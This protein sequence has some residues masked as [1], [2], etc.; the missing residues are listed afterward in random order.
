MTPCFTCPVALGA[1]S[2]ALEKGYE[3]LS[4]FSKVYQ[5]WLG[6]PFSTQG[7][8]KDRPVP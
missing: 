4:G 2:Q 6:Q 3:A 1:G 5:D 8:E 7:R